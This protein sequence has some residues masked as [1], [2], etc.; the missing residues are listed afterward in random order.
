MGKFAPSAI[1]SEASADAAA[2]AATTGR[3]GIPGGGEDG[4]VGEQD[5]RH[6]EE[7]RHPAAH[8]A[9]HCG[10]ACLEVEELHARFGRRSAQGCACSSCAA[11]RKS[12]A[13]SPKRP[14]K[15]EPIGNP[16]PF[17]CKG[18]ESAGWP[19]RLARGVK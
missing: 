7:R 9:G 11:S 15:C 18:T 17:Q 6:G 8:L 3:N 14:K 1:R 2:V 10:A 16:C 4:R 5:V 19:V 12:V 13:S